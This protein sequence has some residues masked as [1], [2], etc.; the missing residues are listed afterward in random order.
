MCRHC[1]EETTPEEACHESLP[2][3]ILALEVATIL[4]ELRSEEAYDKLRSCAEA[5]AFSA[6]NWEEYAHP[7]TRQCASACRMV[8]DYWCANADT[9][10]TIC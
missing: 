3:V 8:F 1:L 6:T 2:D 10:S 4:I 5:C 7:F 9:I